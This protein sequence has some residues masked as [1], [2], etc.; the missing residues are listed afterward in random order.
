MLSLNAISRG[1]ELFNLFSDAVETDMKVGDFITL[2][3]FAAKLQ[4]TSV[5]KRYTIVPPLVT[6]WTTP[7]GASVQLPDTEAIWEQVIKP[8]GYE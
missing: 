7:G 2:L 6:G 5:V 3:P 4:D 8:A 1:P